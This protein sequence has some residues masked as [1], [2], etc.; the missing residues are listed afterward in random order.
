MCSEKPNR[1][2][3]RQTRGFFIFANAFS[4]ERVFAVCRPIFALQV[5]LKRT[6]VQR[7]SDGLF[8][9]E[10]L[11]CFTQKNEEIWKDR[12]ENYLSFFIFTKKKI[13]LAKVT[14]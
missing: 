2:N 14:N 9:T 13:N 10:K 6:I 11:L 7:L 1:K 3:E 5:A 4:S 12:I 8:N